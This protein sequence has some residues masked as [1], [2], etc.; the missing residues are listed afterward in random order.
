MKKMTKPMKPPMK[1]GMPNKKGGMDD[2]KTAPPTAGKGAQAAR[3]KRLANT[4]L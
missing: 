2:E 3:E 1:K 4:P